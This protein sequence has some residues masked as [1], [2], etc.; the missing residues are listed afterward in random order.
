[1]GRG[2][3]SEGGAGLRSVQLPV[4]AVA[5]RGLLQRPVIEPHVQRPGL[6]TGE[7]KCRAREFLL[8]AETLAGNIGDREVRHVDL[9]R[10]PGGC[11]HRPI[12]GRH[13]RHAKEREL[14]TES[15]TVRGG[16]IT[17]EIP[18]FL[19]ERRVWSVIARKFESSR[20][21]GRGECLRGGIPR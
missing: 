5:G 20:L 19:A 6:R 2:R 15:L 4:P 21:E 17:G 12:R 18:P 3:E 7:S 11:R 14:E 13:Q 10:A 8:E 9:A 1:R 16:E